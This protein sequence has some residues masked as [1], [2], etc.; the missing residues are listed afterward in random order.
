MIHNINDTGHVAAH[1]SI[2]ATLTA[3]PGTIATAITAQAEPVGLSAATKTGLARKIGTNIVLSDYLPTGKRPGDPTVEC[4]PAWDAAMADLVTAGGGRLFVD[5][6]FY[7]GRALV[8]TGGHNCQLPIPNVTTYQAHMPIAIEGM[9]YGRTSGSFDQT[10][11]DRGNGQFVSTLTGQTYN[12]A[13][14]LP[15]VIGGP[16]LHNGIATGFSNTDVYLKNIA[17]QTP[18]NPSV[19]GLDLG[20][21]NHAILDGLVY[22]GVDVPGYTVT[23]AQQP[24]NIWAAGVLTPRAANG[25]LTEIN[26]LTVVGF[27]VNLVFG[28]HV[29]ARA[30]ALLSGVI[31]IGFRDGAYNSTVDRAAIEQCAL[32][33]SGWDPSAGAQNLIQAR[34]KM[35]LSVEDQATAGAW[36][37]PYAHV[38]DSNGQAHFDITYSKFNGGNWGKL[39]VVGSGV[40]LRLSDLNSLNGLIAVGSDTFTRADGAMG[41]TEDAVPLTWTAILGSAWRVVSNKAAQPVTPSADGLMAVSAFYTGIGNL[42]DVTI[43]ADLTSGAVKSG[44]GLAFRSNASG[45]AYLV[46]QL[47]SVTGTVKLYRYNGSFSLLVASG[48]VGAI[49]S[50]TRNLKVV[51]AAHRIK[52]YL[53]GLL[54]IDV[55]ISRDEYQITALG[56]YHGLWADSGDDGGTTT[57]DNFKLYY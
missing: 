42:S 37:L 24:L 41:S 4:G 38:N 14:G 28:E 23:N 35:F 32:T 13:V 34:A 46:A 31:A 12:S 40:F 15:S 48:S 2:D 19:C 1:N 7:T 51:A 52:V 17:V 11:Q 25:G 49:L 3:L 9:P 39:G 50:T 36:N 22:V 16:A 10:V 55:A 54:V 18:V 56:T 29:H 8:T 26:A 53:D 33:L 5:G 43:S 30:L 21:V 20:W 57:F 44:A 6:T 47:N 45:T 27:Y